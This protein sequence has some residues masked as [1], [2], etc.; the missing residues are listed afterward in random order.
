MRSSS[1]NNTCIDVYM[2]AMGNGCKN[3]LFA[4]LQSFVLSEGGPN[5][6]SVSTLLV[7]EDFLIEDKQFY[8][9]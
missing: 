7:R 3:K 2:E 9:F 1:C 6:L 8:P 4:F 5:N